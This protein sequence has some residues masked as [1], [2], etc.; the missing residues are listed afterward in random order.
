[1]LL[2]LSGI[3]IPTLWTLFYNTK[4]R[5]YYRVISGDADI[6]SLSATTELQYRLLDKAGQLITFAAEG[7]ILIL[8]LLVFIYP[9]FAGRW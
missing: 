7:F 6:S 9:F 1:M 8:A 4:V 2:I 3:C 5:T